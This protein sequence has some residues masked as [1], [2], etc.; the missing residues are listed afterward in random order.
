LCPFVVVVVRGHRKN[1]GDIRQLR[2]R[3][4]E[5]H[6]QVEEYDGRSKITLQDYRQLN[7]S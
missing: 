1:L 7:G 6:A 5:V 4:I 3:M 2:G